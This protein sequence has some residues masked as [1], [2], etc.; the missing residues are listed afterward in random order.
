MSIYRIHFTWKSKEVTLSAKLLDMTHPYFVSIKEIL[1]PKASSLI[2]DPGREEFEKTFGKANH[3]MIPFQ[4]VSL[5][6]EIDEKD[7]ENEKRIS[8]FSIIETE[9]KN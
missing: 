3:L 7:I 9:R 5:I 8:A 6:E 4:G 1:L 2:I